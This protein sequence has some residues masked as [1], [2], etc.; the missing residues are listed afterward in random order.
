MTVHACTIVARNYLPAAR[1]LAESFREQHPDGEFTVLLIDD[2]DRAVDPAAESFALRYI[3]EIGIEP[4]DLNVMSAIY[5]P[6]E[7]AV[8]AKPWLLE[9]LLRDGTNEVVY[10]D[11]DIRLYGPLDEAVT[12]AA[13]HGIVLTPHV[14]TPM[15]R[16]GKLSD[17][18]TILGSGSYNLG[19]IAV[20]PAAG[21][22]VDFW[23]ERLRRDC[24]VDKPSMH[25]GDQ[26]WTD[27]VPGMFSVHI[28][29]D[30]TYNVAYWNLDHRALEWTGERYEVDGRPLRFFHFSG[31]DPDS[32]HLLSKHQGA[33]PRVLLSEYPAVAKICDEYRNSLLRSGYLEM[34]GTEYGY[35]RTLN[36]VRLDSVMRRTYREE[37]VECETKGFPNPPNPFDGDGSGFLDW[38]SAGPPHRYLLA[39]WRS[40]PDLQREFPNPEGDD[41]AGF[42]QW[43]RAEAAAGILDS[44]VV[45]I[46]ANASS[47]LETTPI[48]LRPGVRLAGRFGPTTEIGRICERVIE[49]V[50][51]DFEVS[52]PPNRMSSSADSGF[53]MGPTR[54]LNMNLVSVIPED[55][56][57]LPD[58]LNEEFFRSRF[59]VAYLDWPYERF[60]ER[61][62]D[63]LDRF[64]EVWVTSEFARNAVAA[65]T[66]IPT[67]VVHPSL[68]EIQLREVPLSESNRRYRFVGI[69]DLADDVDRQNPVGIIEAF[70]KAFEPGQEAMLEIGMLNASNGVAGSEMIRRAAGNRQDI[71]LVKVGSGRSELDEFIAHADCFVSLHRSTAFGLYPALAA[72]QGTPLITVGFGGIV[73][74]VDA[75]TAYLVDWQPK[76]IPTDHDPYFTCSDWAEPIPGDAAHLMRHVFENPD[77]A[78]EVSSRGVTSARGRFGRDVVASQVSSRFVSAQDWMARPPV[79]PRLHAKAGE[80]SELVM[81]AQSR[82]PLDRPSRHPRLARFV[83]RVVLRF[84]RNYDEHQRAIHV[85]LARQIEASERGRVLVGDEDDPALA[86]QQRFADHAVRLER[87]DEYLAEIRKVISAADEDL[88]ELGAQLGHHEARIDRFT[89]PDAA[90]RARGRHAAVVGTQERASRAA[91]G[92]V[93]DHR[94]RGTIRPRL[95]PTRDRVPRAFVSLRSYAR[96][97]QSRRRPFA[98]LPYDP[99]WTRTGT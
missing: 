95:R 77:E 48:E 45:S 18:E 59:N 34:S 13:Q 5:D 22:F 86:M 15:A 91:S 33:T 57:R 11:A 60:S 66:G 79:E 50:Q 14:T 28:L 10:L 30:A 99:R 63:A 88:E 93:P 87:I 75:S 19:F 61:L 46:S 2:R 92:A 68:D 23:K 38:I 35:G 43:A 89:R 44:R 72:M 40:R 26:R 73:E 53:R 62:G 6:M 52:S 3:D 55:L 4:Q 7:L 80:D 27:F 98:P 1:V 94:P 76:Q 67:F 82:P 17:E 58:E 97:A 96:T 83:R 69:V 47:G 12:L 84:L 9:R 39:L 90:R 25:F 81:I 32:P 16:D 64:Q 20:S 49:V 41:A 8:A 85:A 51:D 70:S 21:D 36:G 56:R 54:D 74:Y 29:R 42:A 78:K 37:V 71:A 31:Y 65:G 24:I